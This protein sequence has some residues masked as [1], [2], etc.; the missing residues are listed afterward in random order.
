MQAV[1]LSP[2]VRMAPYYEAI[3]HAEMAR[4]LQLLGYEIE[5][6]KHRYEIKGISRQVIEKFSLRTQEIEA[7]AKKLKIQSAKT[8]AGLGAK[9][10]VNKSKAKEDQSLIQSWKKRLTTKEREEL[11]KVKGKPKPSGLE[12]TPENA[13]EQALQHHLER[14]STVAVKRLLA[15]AMTYGYGK[16]GLKEIQAAYKSNKN[17]VTAQVGYLKHCT[18]KDMIRME[19]QIINYAASTRGTRTPIHPTYRIKRDFL[20]DEQKSCHPQN[21]KVH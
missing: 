16:F 8:K 5:R 14:K 17:I 21:C 15:T 19:D 11:K 10:R 18:T 1:E 2:V 3:Y 7:L 6:G 12:M 20:N 4:G 9:S 13:I